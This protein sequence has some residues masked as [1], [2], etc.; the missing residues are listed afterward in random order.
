MT[1]LENY[2]TYEIDLLSFYLLKSNYLCN[3]RK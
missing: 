2:K 1:S 3:S